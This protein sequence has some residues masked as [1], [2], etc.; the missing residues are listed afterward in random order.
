MEE[1]NIFDKEI[2]SFTTQ[3]NQVLVA[4]DGIVFD[5]FLAI[6]QG[7]G[8][9][10]RIGRKINVVSIQWVWELTL[11][12]EIL[13]LI[14][15]LSDTVRMILYIDH[16]CNGATAA[17]TDIL[18]DADYMAFYKDV[19]ERRFTILD[20]TQ[21]SLYPHAFGAVSEIDIQCPEVN[22]TG[23]GHIELFLPVSFSAAAG[24]IE[25]VSSANIGL[26]YIAK[27]ELITYH[28]ARYRVQYY[29]AD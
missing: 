7:V 27:N 18:E 2:A 24:A 19:N 8:N 12:K 3:A 4:E 15:R 20:D 26:L 9:A 5:T 10:K 25:S 1:E 13:G 23:R 11:K 6:P 21:R 14:A 28:R 17:V 29:D 16:Q 22:V